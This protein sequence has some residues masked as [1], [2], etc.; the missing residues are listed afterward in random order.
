MSIQ[1]L[2]SELN[3]SQRVAAELPKQHAMVLAGAGCGKT[4]TIV[5]RAA[6]L[7]SQ[8][9]PADRVQILTFTRRAAVEI[10]ERVRTHLG[11][12]AVGLHASTFHTWCLSLI[13]RAP[14]LFGY[15]SFTVLDEDDQLSL[16]KLFRG[17]NPPKNFPTADKL[18]SLYSFARNTCQSPRQRAARGG[19]ARSRY[20]E[21]L[22]AGGS[23]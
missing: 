22:T 10:V 19:E 2:L 16:F 14:K 15:R 3:R 9:T 4:K 5:A 18:C 21:H 17:K 20:A 7:I 8:T 23:S 1:T 13:R 6:W 12:A 11:D